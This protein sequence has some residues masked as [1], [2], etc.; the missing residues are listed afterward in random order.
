M[1]PGY[2]Q[3]A[4]V[5]PR[6]APPQPQAIATPP[7]TEQ[8]A[9]PVVSPPD[10][11]LHAVPDMP[12]KAIDEPTE[13][14]ARAWNVS[15]WFVGLYFLGVA[16]G[17]V[18]WLVGMVALVRII[19]TARAAPPHCRQLL[20]EIAGPRSARVRLL[21]SRLAKQ[22]FASV[23]VAVQ[24]PPQRAAWGRAVIVLPENLCDDEQAVRWALAHEWTHIEHRDFRAWFV[25]GLARVLFFY[26]PLV[27]WLRRQLRLCQDYVAD[28][29]ASR[30]AAQPEDYAEFLTV[31]AAAGLLHP[32]MV[33]LGM[34]FSKSE[35]YRRVVMLVQNRPL[36]SRPPR[37]WTVSVTCA[38]LLLAATVAALTISPRRATGS[39][40][41]ANTAVTDA[42]GAVSPDDAGKSKKSPPDAGKAIGK[43][44]DRTKGSPQAPKPAKA[45][46]TLDSLDFASTGGGAG[47]DEET[48]KLIK[49]K[50]YELVKTVDSRSGERQYIYRFTYPDGRRVNRNLSMPLDKV[51]S[52]ADY[53]KKQKLQRE[54]RNERISQSLTSGRFR[55]LNLDV[56]QIHICRDAASGRTFKVQRIQRPDHSEIA[57]PRA[58]FGAIPPSVRETSWKEHLQA[59]RDG[60]RQ[61]LKL[62]TLNAYTYEM[63]AD[64]GTKDIFAYGGDD[65]LEAMLKRSAGQ[66][67]SS[68]VLT[69]TTPSTPA[70]PGTTERVIG[71]RP[72]GKCS[73]SGK[74]VSESTGKP[75]AGAN[76]YLFYNVTYGS[77]FINTDS[78]GAFAFKDIPRGPF[79]FRS[80]NRAGYQDAVYDPEGT[81]G[82]F[83]PFQL[84][85]GEQRSGILLKAKEACRVAGVI[86]EEN[87]NEP[88]DT[89]SMA[90]CAWFKADDGEEYS[91]AQGR[92]KADGS[93]LVDGLSGKP[94]YMMAVNWRNEEQGDGY[95]A[96][97]APGTFFRGE[98]KRVTF[99]KSRS[100]E[101]VNITLRKTGG[102]VLE[103]TVRDEKGKPIPEAFVVVHHRDMLF[104]RVTTYSDAQGH[105]ELQALGDGEVLVNVDAMHRG[106]VRTRAPLALDKK[107]PKVRRDFILHRGVLISGKLVDQD[108]KEWEIGRSHGEAHVTKDPKEPERRY[109]SS[110]SGLPNKH[111]AQGVRES[112]AVFY[113]PGEGEYDRGEMVF[114]TRSTFVFQGMKPGHTLITLSPQEEGKKVIRIL[115]NGQ[116]IRKSGLDT[117]AGEEIKH[118][119]IVIG[120]EQG[121]DKSKGN[122]AQPGKAKG[123]SEKT[124]P[125]RSSSTAEEPKPLVSSISP[126]EKAKAL[127]HYDK[128]VGPLT[129]E[130]K[131]AETYAKEWDH[132]RHKVDVSI[133]TIS[134]PTSLKLGFKPHADFDLPVI[135]VCASY[136][137]KT[138]GAAS[139]PQPPAWYNVTAG[140]ATSTDAIEDGKLAIRI[141]TEQMATKSRFHR[142]EMAGGEC[143]IVPYRFT[144]DYFQVLGGTPKKV[145]RSEVNIPCALVASWLTFRYPTEELLAPGTKWI[146]PNNSDSSDGNLSCEVV[147]FAEVGGRQ[148]VK[149]RGEKQ[150]S[151]KPVVTVGRID[152]S[153]KYSQQPSHEE[154]T[155]QAVETVRK[156]AYV[157]LLAGITLRQEIT[158]LDPDIGQTAVTIFQVLDH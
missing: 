22:P 84:R 67:S 66:V 142:Q 43:P 40:G 34:G 53:Q 125:S 113:I 130:K 134:G 29:Q 146:N 145:P 41:D 132:G 98:A 158:I 26:Q 96:I 30:Q 124:T 78:D 83:P 46:I 47:I 76:M 147:G 15:L 2:P 103:G 45:K 39:G 93:Y 144:R 74:L 107:T 82:Q 95:P 60:K 54:Q 44:A 77:I 111:G 38:A 87:G 154:G 118:I 63:T 33:G 32:A 114:P 3:L 69:V 122:A 143:A 153:G 42:A 65:P 136:D 37:L 20:A 109:S 57:L 129:L 85:D 123:A 13:T 9:V 8:V 89:Q 71:V 128:S 108:G 21:I 106:F 64:D 138:S 50:K 6:A 12:R 56:I 55:L 18:W 101:G 116:D 11:V 126:D 36:E 7:P 139:Y 1:I 17:I 73:L 61:L 49:E 119:T 27:W 81:S 90:I 25:A 31:R 72:R 157:D 52:W 99:D 68:R 58:D 150:V 97:Y 79:S 121:G 110:W 115:H 16:L 62:E 91:L 5:R 137:Q 127:R 4:I 120:T 70:T 86:R 151:Y 59:I 35:L 48:G 152:A 88:S 133:K 155:T 131:D 149:I 28:A 141:C 112:S 105:Y 92:V 135:A 156:V 51:T 23:G 148:T 102:L 14:P 117:K 19:W 94:V 104:D 10:V 75:I 24:L 140:R 80:S 100:V